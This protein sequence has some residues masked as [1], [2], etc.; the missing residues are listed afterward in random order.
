[1]S[2]RGDIRA[3][4]LTG[5]GI[6]GPI[7]CR[8][9][10]EGGTDC[11][12]LLSVFINANRE[13]RMKINR[14]FF[15]FSGVLFLAVTAVAAQDMGAENMVLHGGS[16]GEVP[17]PHHLHQEVLGGDCNACHSFFPQ[18]KGAIEKNK[19]TGELKKKA[20]MNKLCIKCHRAAENAGK[21]AGPVKCGECH[22]K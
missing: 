2:A 4:F 8:T 11:S 6:Q 15:V 9:F 5:H 21:K 13:R 7:H 3:G 12:C 20:V 16:K 1:M 19:S 18:E 10:K 17:F 22:I 14:F